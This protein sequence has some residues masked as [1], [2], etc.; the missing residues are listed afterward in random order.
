MMRT[1]LTRSL[2][3]FALAL[4]VAAACGYDPNPASGTLKC[5]P[6]NSCPD[7]YTCMS[8]ACWANGAAGSTGTGHGGSGGGMGGTGGSTSVDKFIGHWLFAAGAQRVRVCP[9]VNE[10]LSL[11][12]D[13]FDVYPG[14][15]S[16]LSASYYCSWN[17]DVTGGGTMTAIRSGTTCSAPDPNVPTTM[18]TWTGEAFTL[19]PAAGNTGTIDASIPYTYTSSTGSGSCT[20]HF[21]GPVTK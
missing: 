11:V 7:N 18:F 16:P 17:L 12:G 20:M 13:Y 2:L 3:G 1:I 15:V 4:T 6:K 14:T 8:G 19:T 21:T 10:T 9:G 5:G